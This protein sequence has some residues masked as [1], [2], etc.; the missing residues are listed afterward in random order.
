MGKSLVSALAAAA[1]LAASFSASAQTPAPTAAPIP[2]PAPTPAPATTPVPAAAPAPAAAP[3]PEASTPATPERPALTA[4]DVSKAFIEGMTLCAK[5]AFRKQ[6]VAQL[7]APDRALVA[8][9]D[10]Q[11]R[12]FAQVPDGRP[13]FDVLS[14]SGIVVISER[15]PGSCE[16]LAYG[17][18]VRPTFQRAGDALVGLHMSYVETENGETAAEVFRTYERVSATGEKVSARFV[19]GEPGMEGRTFRFP[20][21]N[22]FFSRSGGAQIN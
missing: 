15:E 1:V 18:R 21:L 9:A 19:G 4:D 6:S 2:T 12:T 14:A 20:V 11:L 3:T 10:Q 13:A 8:Q 7:P 5:A 22:V 17:P 16:V